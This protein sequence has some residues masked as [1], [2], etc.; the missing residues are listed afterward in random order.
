MYIRLHSRFESRLAAHR[1]CA[2]LAYHLSP[3]PCPTTLPP[4][5]SPGPCQVAQLR[6]RPV[7][8]QSAFLVPPFHTSAF[9]SPRPFLPTSTKANVSVRRSALLWHK[10]PLS[11]R[12]PFPLILHSRC[13]CCC[14]CCHRCD[15]S[16]SAHF[17]RR[18]GERGKI[19]SG[20]PC[21]GYPEIKNCNLGTRSLDRNRYDPPSTM[22]F[23]ACQYRIPDYASLEAPRVGS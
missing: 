8:L 6:L 7:P 14:C 19:R 18:R 12:I 16:F 21:Q 11:S 2:L 1:F 15:S 5:S 10:P 3:P 23:L 20:S 17:Q 13:C 22:S 9:S 4:P